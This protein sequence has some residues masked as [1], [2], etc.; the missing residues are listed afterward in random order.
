MA[1]RSVQPF[2]T[3][4]G[5]VSSGMPGHALSPNNWPFT[6]GIWAPYNTC[7]LES[8]R[9][10]NPNGISIRSAVHAQLMADCPYTLQWALPPKNYPFSWGIWTPSNTLHCSLGSPVST[11]QTASRSLQQFLHRWPQSVPILYSGTPLSQKI[12]PSHW[13]AGFHLIHG[14]LGPP[15]SSTRFS[16]FSRAHYYDKQ[17]DQQ[18]DHATQS[19]T[20][21]CI[22]IC[23]TAMRPENECLVVTITK[24]LIH[25]KV[26]QKCLRLQWNNTLGTKN[27]TT[28]TKLSAALGSNSNGFINN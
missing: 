3:A 1:N 27:Y 9:V 11:T 17:T 21:G 2:F 8:T 12:A 23:S 5:R 15:W 13:G 24:K 10:H 22:Y 28:K 4:H 18:R 20:I 6:C 19:V 26:S 14:S 7:F 25:K 16:H